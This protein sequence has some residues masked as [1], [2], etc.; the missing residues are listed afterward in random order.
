MDKLTTPGVTGRSIT[1]PGGRR[2][3]SHSAAAALRG[4]NPKTLDRWVEA[5]LIPPPEIVNRRKYHFLA[6]I[7]DVPVDQAREGQAA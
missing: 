4:V 5:G 7:D 2:R 1:M 3:I 6:D